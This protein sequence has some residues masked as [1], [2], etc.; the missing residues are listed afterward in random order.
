MNKIKDL[1]QTLKRTSALPTLLAALLLS[2]C[3]DGTESSSNEVVDSLSQPSGND[4]VPLDN[5]ERSRDTD[6]VEQQTEPNSGVSMDN[7]NRSP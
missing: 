3:N 7:L 6:T 2:A 5:L 4:G 1:Y